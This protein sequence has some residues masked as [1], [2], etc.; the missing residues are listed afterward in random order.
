MMRLKT[1][2]ESHYPIPSQGI[3]SI[4][5]RE[6]YS[7]RYFEKLTV[8][9]ASLK[10]RYLEDYGIASQKVKVLPDAA[11][12][13]G[14]AE[15][16]ENWPG[17][18]DA[19]QVGYVGHLYPGKGIEIIEKLCK[20]IPHMD[21]N[22]VGGT[23]PDI[24]KWRKRIHSENLFFHGHVPPNRISKYINRLHVCLLP[25][26]KEVLT[27]ESVRKSD[28]NISDYSSPLKLFEYMGH[29]KAIVASD[30]PVLREVLNEKNAILVP[31][32][33]VE[34]WKSA[35]L[36][37]EDETLR[38]RLGSSAYQDFQTR[39]TWTIRAQKALP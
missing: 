29:A 28:L 3:K 36:A 14:S 37:L 24:L 5:F 13:P 22:I 34:Q 17:R 38:E 9:S 1:I 39:Y 7:S 19:L 27:H 8:I 23:E 4:L 30:L 11:D 15:I 12:E 35:I 2:F 33:D 32:D 26:Q 16:I 20:V 18:N 10:N 21:F 31:C 6:M 25:N